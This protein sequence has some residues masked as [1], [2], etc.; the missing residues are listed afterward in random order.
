MF[1]LRR[2][3]SISQIDHFLDIGIIKN[4]CKNNDSKSS[5]LKG[6][7]DNAASFNDLNPSCPEQEWATLPY[8]EGTKIRK[9]GEFFR[10]EKHD[11]RETSIILFPGQGTQ[12][13]GMTK[14]LMKFPIVQD[15][16]E[17]ANYIL[18]YDLQKLCL[19]G[20]KEKLDQTKYAQPAI[21]VASLAAIERL[22]EER[23]NAVDRCVA[24]AGFSLGEITALVFAGALEFEK[25]LQL[26]QIRAEAMQM[27]C[28]TYK[29]GMA[30]V[31]LAPDSKLNYC[32][33]KARQ[34]AT[35]KGDQMPECRIA[36]YLNPGCKVIAG[37]ISALDY[38]EKN[39]KEFNLKKVKRLPV[40]GAFH[41]ELMRPAVQPFREALNSVKIS[42][43]V[44]TVYSN[45]DG[46]RYN[47]A[48]H[49]KKQLPSQIVKPVKWEQ[50]L[51]YVYERGADDYFPKSFECGPGQSL[52]AMLQKVNAKAWNYC[53]SIEA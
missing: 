11:A 49:I 8:L 48:L 34:W 3:L 22:K 20:P 51:H 23:P 42:D 28:E 36:N 32:L 41:S 17:L 12:Y 40:S 1:A 39:Y 19:E 16:F 27:A 33:L 37:S 26:V 50:L 25:A 43:P 9:Q 2:R 18:K 13:V 47:S 6:L 7:L 4:Y 46:K 29:G 52:K 15:L 53:Y 30:T 14:N 38:V 10:K 35:D 5:P 45:V 31:F 21:M 44:V 24:T